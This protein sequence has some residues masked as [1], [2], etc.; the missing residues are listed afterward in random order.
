MPILFTIYGTFT[1]IALGVFLHD[2]RFITVRKHK[3]W[4]KYFRKKKRQNGNEEIL[5]SVSSSDE[6]EEDEYQM[7]P[8]RMLRRK[9]ERLM[10]KTG[11]QSVI[12]PE[13][14]MEYV[15]NDGDMEE[16]ENEAEKRACAAAKSVKREIVDQCPRGFTIHSDS[17]DDS[18]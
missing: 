13:S 7:N 9:F 18:E 4:M 1:T 12:Q 10:T 15:E 3:K 16:V 6:E 8:I 5:K 14:I 2:R 17:E 11:W